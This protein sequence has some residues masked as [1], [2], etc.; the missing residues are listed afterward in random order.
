MKL[1]EKMA[2]IKK[3]ANEKRQ[4]FFKNN[5][6]PDLPVRGIWRGFS[7]WMAAIREDGFVGGESGAR[8]EI[9]DKALEFFRAI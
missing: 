9:V 2:E 4:T 1:D 7:R 5:P 6:N 8:S 3:L